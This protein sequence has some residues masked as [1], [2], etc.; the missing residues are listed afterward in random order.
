MPRLLICK[1]CQSIEVMPLWEGP[2]ELEADDPVLDYLVQQHVVRHGDMLSDAAVLMNVEDKYWDDL[3]VRDEIL[4]GMNRRWVGFEPT[5]YHIM[6]TFS[7]DALRCYSKHHRPKE[8]CPD[9]HAPNKVLGSQLWHSEMDDMADKKVA[10]RF[11]KFAKD[12]DEIVYLCDWCP[13]QTWVQTKL[14]TKAG[15]YKGRIDG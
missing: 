12:P 11:A 1:P 4:R 2:A 5:A 7:E 8:G 13:V 3:T 6:D 15:L 10:K 9:Y 14:N